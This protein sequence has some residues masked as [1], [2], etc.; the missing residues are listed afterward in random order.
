MTSPVTR[1]VLGVDGMTCH[2]CVSLIQSA[3]QDIEGVHSVS[4]SLEEKC[5]SIVYE[6]T[7]TSS[8]VFIAAIEDVGF[9]FTGMSGMK[10]RN[11]HTFLNGIV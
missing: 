6:S 8:E 2:S 10:C 9:I 11:T 1:T 3:L 4:V 5:A 7:K